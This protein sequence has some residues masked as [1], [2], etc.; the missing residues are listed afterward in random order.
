MFDLT[1]FDI[2]NI[3]TSN[4]MEKNATLKKSIKQTIVVIMGI[5]I[6]A[7]I[8]YYLYKYLY[9]D[10][11]RESFTSKQCPNILIQKG[12]HIFLHNSNL[13]K[14]PGVNPIEFNNLEDYVEYVKWQRSQKINCPVLFLQHS[15]DAQGNSVYKNRPSPMEL[16]GG[17]PS[18]SNLELNKINRSKLLDAG[19]DDPPYNKNLYPGFD[20]QNQY[21][22][23]YTPLDKMY[24]QDPG[25]VS[26]SAMDK[27]W[28]G[29]KY[30]QKLINK[31]VYEE[32]N[33]K[34]KIPD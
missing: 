1:N 6:F 10:K 19:H 27:N 15:Y 13:A 33:V 22:G 5:I 29:P 12:K 21:I 7:L 24:H 16:E 8:A 3:F 4:Y 32:D 14:I 18:I 20:A 23:L 17:L 26:P 34:I 30:T 11:L 31:G 25:G 2:F 9:P 28:G